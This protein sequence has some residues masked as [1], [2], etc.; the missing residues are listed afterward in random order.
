[1][2]CQ[3]K[4]RK[5]I[6]C[7]R[8]AYQEVNGFYLCPSHVLKTPYMKSKKTIKSKVIILGEPRMVYE[9]INVFDFDYVDMEDEYDFSIIISDNKEEIQYYYDNLIEETK[10]KAKVL[11]VSDLKNVE[12]DM[13][14]DFPVRLISKNDIFI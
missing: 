4:T 6:R 9:F 14:D 1:M 7:K 8:K 2:N 3:A 10:Y 11:I 12:L 13:V 5:G